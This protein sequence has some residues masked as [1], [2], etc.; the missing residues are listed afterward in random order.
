MYWL[1]NICGIRYY[2][3]FASIKNEVNT[4]NFAYYF[5]YDKKVVEKSHRLTKKGDT[6][7]YYDALDEVNRIF[8]IGK[9]KE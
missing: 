6:R 8:Q 5:V 9:S 3:A 4:L 1:Q 2:L 7:I